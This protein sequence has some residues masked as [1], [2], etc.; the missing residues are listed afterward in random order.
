[1]RGYFKRQIQLWGEQ[2]Q[3][4]LKDKSILILGCGGLGCSLAYAL[5][6]SG[7]GKIYLVDFDTISLHNIHRQLAFEVQDEGRYKSEVLAQKMQKR[8]IQGVEIVPFTCSFEDFCKKNL[9]VDLILDAS[10][11]LHVRAQMDEYSK[12]TKIPWIYGSVEEYRGQVCFFDKA[13]F[14]KTFKV[15]DIE[16]KGQI[17]PM[18]MLM[19]S[20]EANIAIKY[21]IGQEI[22]KDKLFY[23][24]FDGEFKSQAFKI[25]S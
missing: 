12:K 9:H 1:M 3:D 4:S 22:Q 17:A 20:F 24:S 14:S 5:A 6:T 13:D 19:A 15:Q 2:T 11:N 23:L 25:S 7:V 10:D 16:P 21:L 8:T 18:V